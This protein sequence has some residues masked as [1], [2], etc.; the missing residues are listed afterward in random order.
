MVTTMVITSRSLQAE[1]KSTYCP[2]YPHARLKGALRMDSRIITNKTPSTIDELHVEGINTLGYG[3]IP[4]AVMFDRTLPLAA[5]GIYGYLCTYTGAGNTAFPSINKLTYDLHIT[6]D[7]YYKYMQL[8]TDAG[9]ITI[10]NI[11]TNGKF[12]HNIYTLVNKPKKYMHPIQD[13][14]TI[15][16]R[17]TVQL[18][19]SHG[20]TGAGYGRIAKIPMCD[21]RIKLEAKALY[22]FLCSLAGSANM[23]FPDTS[24]LNY[25]LG[26]N[27]ST[28]QTYRKKLIGLGY[29]SVEHKRDG[30]RFN[31][32]HYCINDTVPDVSTAYQPMPPQ[33][34]LPETINSETAEPQT[35]KSEMENVYTIRNKDNTTKL[36][37]NNPSFVNKTSSL[38][39]T[40]GWMDFVNYRLKSG[41]LDYERVLISPDSIYNFTS[42]LFFNF[43]TYTNEAMH[44]IA[45]MIPDAIIKLLSSKSSRVNGGTVVPTQVLHLIDRQLEIIDYY[46]YISIDGVIDRTVQKYLDGAGETLIKYPSRYLIACLID[47]LTEG[48]AYTY[49]EQC[50]IDHKLNNTN[51]NLTRLT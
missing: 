38:A 37:N 35:D 15:E 19:K 39:Q 34:D 27:P 41:H 23:A 11:K 44:N 10:H 48:D 20:L 42:T 26:I 16:E 2:L 46:P 24:S 13:D 28:S 17:K 40:D 43:N 5:K 18:V 32:L 29:I 9:Y 36:K 47:A 50:F 4:K 22:C 33:L 7:T 51:D 25:Y 30:G 3:I 45:E 21:R 1:R 12:G 31:G 49:T 8:L 14:Y 6:K